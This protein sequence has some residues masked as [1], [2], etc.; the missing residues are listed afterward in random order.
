MIETASGPAQ[1]NFPKHDGEALARSMRAGSEVALAAELET[2]K[3]DHPIYRAGHEEAQASG[4][5][6]RLNYA[7]HGAVNGYHLDDGTFIHVGPH[8]AKKYKLSV[9]ESV[10]ATGSRRSGTDA[11]VLEVHAVERMAAP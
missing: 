3:G 9:G 10:K 11:V 8:E 6:L 4:I 2:D 5:I 1:I 7:L